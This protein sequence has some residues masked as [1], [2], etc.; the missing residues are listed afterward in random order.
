[1]SFLPYVIY[2]VFVAKEICG[3][4]S[5]NFLDRYQLFGR[6]CCLGTAGNISIC[7]GDVIFQQN[8]ASISLPPEPQIHHV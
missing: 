6:S 5:Y 4:T 8:L 1:M 7:E 2:E 3:M